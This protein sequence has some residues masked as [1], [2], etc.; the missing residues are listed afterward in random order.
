MPAGVR[1]MLLWEALLTFV[2]VVAGGI[3]YTGVVSAKAAG[4]AVLFAQAANFATVVYKTGQ[5][6]MP[7]GSQQLPPTI[8]VQ[9]QHADPPR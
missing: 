7:P 4:L 9:G 3:G 1:L 8:I 5:W 2:T 6:Q